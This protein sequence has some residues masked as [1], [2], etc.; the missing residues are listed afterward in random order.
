MNFPS[1]RLQNESRIGES[2]VFSPVAALRFA[3]LHP[4]TSKTSKLFSSL[5][6]F[7]RT[8]LS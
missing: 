1:R 6:S 3:F 7:V 2:T 4:T 8:D 5:F